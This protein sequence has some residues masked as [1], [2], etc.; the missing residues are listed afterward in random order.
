MTNTTVRRKLVTI[1]DQAR[2]I[3]RYYR[4][5]PLKDIPAVSNGKLIEEAIRKVLLDNGIGPVPTYGVVDLAVVKWEV[6]IQV[7]TYR[8]KAGQLIFSRTSVGGS[9]AD[10]IKDIYTRIKTSFDKTDTR[11]LLLLDMDVFSS[12]FE[13]F[14][15]AELDARGKVVVKGSF[16]QPDHVQ[17]TPNNTHFRIKK[18]GLMTI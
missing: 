5:G 4:V 11:R 16:L 6:G 12:N 1:L 14:D 10:R 18:N 9:K 13:L 2:E 8:R 17:V 15:L 7:K 3:V